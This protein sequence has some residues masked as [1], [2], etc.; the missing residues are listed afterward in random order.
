MQPVLWQSQ[1]TARYHSALQTLRHKG[2]VYGCACTRKDIANTRATH[3][4]NPQQRHA[5]LIYPGTCRL[6]PPVH[7]IRSWRFAIPSGTGTLSWTD[8]RLG[9]QHQDIAHAV[10]DFV[11]LRADGYVA[12]QLAVVVDD[13]DQGITHIVRGE[14]LADNTPRQILLQTALGAPQ[15]RYMHTPLVYASPG[16]KLSKHQGAHPAATAERPLEVLCH[17]AQALGLMTDLPVDTTLSD[18][19]SSWVQQ[20][21]SVWADHVKGAPAYNPPR[22]LQN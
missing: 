8:R 21:R 17:A 2:Q 6:V 18:A 13:L 12:Y 1:R 19:L 15:P 20:W 11:L 5:E 9:L 10:G 14:D 4:A 22:D 3:N 16:N 7:P